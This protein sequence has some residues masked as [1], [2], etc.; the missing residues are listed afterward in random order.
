MDLT[1]LLWIQAHLRCE[2]LDVFFRIFTHLGDFGIFWILLTTLLLIRPQTRYTGV[3][4]GLSL[5]ASVIFT[6]AVIKPLVDRPRPFELFPL[7]LLITPPVSSSFPSG[8]TSASFAAA[9]A[10]FITDKKGFWRWFLMAVA[11]LIALS[12]LYLFVHNPTDVLAGA[13]LGTVLAFVCTALLSRTK[14]RDR[15]SA[16]V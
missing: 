3:V 4:M 12:R 2:A 5:L 14:L 15:W 6:E 16:H 10:F 9:T 1:T 8:H 7:D 11:L 13:V